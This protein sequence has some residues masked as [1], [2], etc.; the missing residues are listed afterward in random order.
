MSPLDLHIRTDGLYLYSPSTNTGIRIPIAGIATYAPDQIA[1]TEALRL[2]LIPVDEASVSD[3]VASVLYH[4]IPA[5]HPSDS[6]IP[7]SYR[8]THANC[9]P[10]LQTILKAVTKC[11]DHLPPPSDEP[12]PIISGGGIVAGDHGYVIGGQLDG[13][14]GDEDIGVDDV[15]RVQGLENF[16]GWVTSENVDEVMR[17]HG[18]TNGGDDGGVNGV[19]GDTEALGQGAGA[20]RQRDDDAEEYDGERV[21]VWRRGE[22]A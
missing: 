8:D 22:D 13:N 12:H 1:N 18:L 10:A 3:D 5:I 16:S 11:Q 7:S 2:D 15:V 19:H 17:A 4:I 6:E 14:G 20:R 9:S 21:V